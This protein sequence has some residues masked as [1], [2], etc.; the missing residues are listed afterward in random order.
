[1]SDEK[2]LRDKFWTEHWPDFMDSVLSLELKSAAPPPARK[3]VALKGDG[4][5][6]LV[7]ESIDQ[8]KK[9]DSS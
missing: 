8:F 9:A 7:Q 2:D 6:R 3:R 1:M 5:G 4:G